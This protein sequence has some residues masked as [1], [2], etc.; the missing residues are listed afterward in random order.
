M[1]CVAFHVPVVGALGFAKLAVC[2]QNVVLRGGQMGMAGWIDVFSRGTLRKND[3]ASDEPHP[4]STA[5][6]KVANVH[7]GNLRPTNCH[8]GREAVDIAADISRANNTPGGRHKAQGLKPAASNVEAAATLE[9]FGGDSS[10]EESTD[11]SDIGYA[12]GLDVGDGSGIEELDEKPESDEEYGGDIRDADE[13]ENP[14][15]RA[16]PIA[17]VSDEERA[18]DGGDGSAGTEVGDGGGGADGDL[19]EHGDGSPEQIE[20]EVA[21]GVHGVLDLGAKGPEENHVADDVQPATMHEHGGEEGD[22][23]TA[24][25]DVGGDHGPLEDE[26]VSAEEFFEK[27]GGVDGDDEGR[28]E[29]EMACAPGCVG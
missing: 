2:L 1:R 23:V 27:D 12:T 5:K 16:N 22:P 10:E 29:R 25:D 20:D 13:Y 18:H 14:E 7:S 21:Q 9:E 15:E 17:G 3:T 6:Y 26:G 28:D 24:G 19:G 4:E 11:V 8:S